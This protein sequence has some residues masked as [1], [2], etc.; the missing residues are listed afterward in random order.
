MLV[1]ATFE[2][3]VVVA[4]RNRRDF[5]PGIVQV[6]Q[7]EGAVAARLFDVQYLLDAVFVFQPQRSVMC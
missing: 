5:P 6:E 7:L 2:Q 1:V 3:R 4:L